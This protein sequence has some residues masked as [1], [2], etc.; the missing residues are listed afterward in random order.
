MEITSLN[1]LR[2][3]LKAKL[4]KV[5][6]FGTGSAFVRDKIDCIS[7]D[8][9]SLPADVDLS[10]TDNE[11]E[12]LEDRLDKTEA[13]L[14]SLSN[15][16]RENSTV[17]LSTAV[18]FVQNCYGDKFKCRVILDSASQIN[19]ISSEF[20]TLLKLKRE[21]IYAPVSGINESV[22]TVKSR[23]YGTI[24][25]KNESFNAELEFLVIPKITGLTPSVALNISG[26]Q[27]PQGIQLADPEFFKPG[28]VDML[29]GA[30]FSEF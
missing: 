30:D 13:P 10:E 8:Y 3:A 27:L 9:Y 5:E 24:F 15:T 21:K 6:L 20:A 11:L 18:L 12:Q 2:G 28:K 26:I 25:N 14:Q 22:Q 1:R 23:V 19:L 7:K 16:A 4:K 29:L 17:S